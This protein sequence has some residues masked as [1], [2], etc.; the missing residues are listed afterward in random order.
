MR[1]YQHIKNNM[2]KNV[3]ILIELCLIDLYASTNN[4]SIG[5][6]INFIISI[7]KYFFEYD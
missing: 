2:M 4:L 7:T 3:S 6:K 1:R 5:L